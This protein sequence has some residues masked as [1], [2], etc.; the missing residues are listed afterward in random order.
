MF[1]EVSPR[2]DLLNAVLSL[3][4]DRAWRYRLWEA[5]PEPARVVVDVC[6]GSG[7]SLAGLR[8]PGRTLLGVDASAEMLALA[9]ERYGHRIGGPGFARADAFRL[10]LADASA[11]AL[12]IAFGLR[13]LRPR[14]EALREFARVLRPG[15]TLA[16]L[17]A[18][19]PGRGR[20]ARLH[21]FYLRWVVPTL[22]WLSPEPRAYLYLSR[23]IQEFGD[24]SALGG[25][26]RAAG[27]ET[28]GGRAFLGGATRLWAAR[29]ESGAAQ[30]AAGQAAIMRNASPAGA[31]GGGT[32]PAA[33]QRRREWMLWRGVLLGLN[34]GMFGLLLFALGVY[35]SF[36][37]EKNLSNWATAVGW[38]LFVFALLLTGIRSLVMLARLRYPPEDR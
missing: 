7:A 25:E 32:S 34:L 24:G 30:S 28:P 31:A 17:E 27:F 10:P 26:L 13:N 14:R 21:R 4:Q 16:I 2:Y 8:R 11:D 19:A 37:A 36:L 18:T 6:C 22:G 12:V 23:S 33:R 1:S 20:L 15:G 5:V 38:V 3:G 29:R 9:A 35:R